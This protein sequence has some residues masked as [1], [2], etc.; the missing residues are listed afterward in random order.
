[1]RLLNITALTLAI[2]L[3]G[4]SKPSDGTYTLYRNSVL[5]PSMRLHFATFDA[6]DGE[7]YNQE[8]CN[9]TKDLI[10]KVNNNVTRFWC[11]KG[12]YRK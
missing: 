7:A 8:N 1:M 5:D 3:I 12:I 10:D 6:S 9:L 4:C 2:L 11:E